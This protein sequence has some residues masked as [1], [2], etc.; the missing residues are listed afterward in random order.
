MK[1]DV[2]IKNKVNF[3]KVQKAMNRAVKKSLG[4][5]AGTVRKIAQRS[6]KKGKAKEEEYDLHMFT[7]GGRKLMTVREYLSKRGTSKNIRVVSKGD[8]TVTDLKEK[9]SYRVQKGAAA[10]SPPRTWETK[11]PGWYD[12]WLK[13]SIVYNVYPDEGRAQIISKPSKNPG[14]SF[15][16][17]PQT[18]EF[19]GSVVDNRRRLLG[20]HINTETESKKGKN[21][22][23]KK[24]KQVRVHY[25]PLVVR[26]SGVQETKEKEQPRIAVK[27]RPFMEPALEKYKS[28]IPTAWRDAVRAEFK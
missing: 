7:P 19:G 12:F 6:I 11:K 5:A 16:E 21:G 14:K 22:R 27:S 1:I 2:N 10:G 17:L 13:K 20:Y 9:E 25:T 18:I 24:Y 8:R 4:Q 15:G 26:P 3:A 28:K 23:I